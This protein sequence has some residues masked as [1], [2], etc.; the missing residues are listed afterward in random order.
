MS[1]TIKLPGRVENAE[2]GGYVANASDIFDVN[3]NKSQSECNAGFD[4][5]LNNLTNDKQDVLTFDNEPT[6]GS[7]NPVK[8]G[9]VYSANLTLSQAIEAILI[10][11]P[12]AASELNKLADEAFVNSTVST[13]TAT[14]R[15][16]YNVVSDLGLAYNATHAQIEAA[17]LSHIATADN[18]DY[19]FVKI[20]VSGT[21]TDIAKTERY[22]FN[23]EAWAYE[24]DLNNSGFTQA[25]WDAI[26]STITLALVQKLSELPTSAE[27][28][29]LFNAKQDN[30][31]FDDAPTAGSNNPV[32]SGG[33]K[34]ALNELDA[35]KQNVL[36]FDSTPTQQSTNPVTSGGTYAAI[37]VVQAALNALTGRVTVNENNIAINTSDIAV[38]QSLYQALT[39]S[40]IVIGAL[41]A[42]GAANTIYRVPGTT[43]YTD[44]A[45]N[46]STFVPLA[47]YDNAIDNVP[48]RGSNNLVKSGGVYTAIKDQSELQIASDYAQIGKYYD[49]NTGTISNQGNYFC[50]LTFQAKKGD[51][52]YLPPA[53]TGIYSLAYV[54]TGAADISHSNPSVVG[55]NT[56]C[57]N[58]TADNTLVYVNCYYGSG[59]TIA[60]LDTKPFYWF[61]GAGIY[62]DYRYKDYFKEYNIPYSSIKVGS[63][64]NGTSVVTGQG[65]NFGCLTIELKAG[66]FLAI[67]K[68]ASEASG[69]QSG[70]EYVRFSNFVGHTIFKATADGTYYINFYWNYQSQSLADIVSSI[71]TIKTNNPFCMQIEENYDRTTDLYSRVATTDAYK[72]KNKS[73][74]W[75]GTSIG[76]GG[77]YAE[78]SAANLGMTC[79]NNCKGESCLHAGLAKSLMNTLAEC[80]AMPAEY[81]DI[82]I[83]HSFE[84]LVLPYINGSNGYTQVSAIVIDHGFNDS[85]LIGQEI[86][87]IDNI[88]W[89]SM[90]RTTYYGAFNYLI[91]EIWKYN[92]RMPIIIAGNY[93]SCDFDFPNYAIKIYNSP[94]VKM[95][96]LL[97][98]KF[99]IPVM[100]V[101]N[102]L[103]FSN[104]IVPNSSTYVQN[105]NTQYGRD[106]QVYWADANDNI[107]AMQYWC[108]DGVHPHSDPTGKAKTKYSQVVTKLLRELVQTV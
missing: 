82:A 101:W 93:T 85:G 10:L 69:G 90:D 72:S 20:P 50:L 103:G 102:Y 78:N 95:Q 99:N 91:N 65:N 60:F 32:K 19:S 36:T 88:D 43:S 42:S 61:R 62:W 31:T 34:T 27:L 2:T 66:E 44:Y 13:N 97:G 17:L 76:N 49:P 81:R 46:G 11:I 23:G 74:L 98:E 4:E 3:K 106:Y 24:Y 45:W 41:P 75:L 52:L 38:L 96:K 48:T 8:S 12:A 83:A 40:A 35:Q 86:E 16:T 64:F 107:T 58:V 104:K 51:F 84:T 108:P 94:V 71:V 70:L 25:Q 105:V 28:Q 26:N 37:A 67:N 5:K 73:V 92:P 6:E 56:I 55:V 79:I 77:T 59:F 100:D 89:D 7:S 18:N 53:G 54:A 15:G 21:S 47:T 57:I 63:Y 87:D 14:F 29:Q 33:I 80:E 1:R 39:Q 22:K 9:G 30:L 68:G